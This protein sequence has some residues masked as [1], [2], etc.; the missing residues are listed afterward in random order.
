[1][2]RAY[3]FSKLVNCANTLNHL[4][5]IEYRNNGMK[6]VWTDLH[7]LLEGQKAADLYDFFNILTNKD[8]IVVL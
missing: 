3:D 6:Y 7:P 5:A 2:E 1:M 4:A 8:V